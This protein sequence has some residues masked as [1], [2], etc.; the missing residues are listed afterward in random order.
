MNIYERCILLHAGTTDW[1]DVD[2]TSTDNNDT[3]ICILACMSRKNELQRKTIKSFERFAEE[4]FTVS[5]RWPA[6]AYEV[7]IAITDR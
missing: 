3:T 6:F 5:R 1:N 2:Q 4:R 7:Y